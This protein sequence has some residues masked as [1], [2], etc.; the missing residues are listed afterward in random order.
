[1][2]TQAIFQKPPWK[3]G[4]GGGGLCAPVFLSWIVKDPQDPVA[5]SSSLR[6]SAPAAG[7]ET[8]ERVTAG[9]EVGVAVG[10]RGFGLSGAAAR[11]R[12][13]RQ[14]ARQLAGWMEP[15]QRP[16]VSARGCSA[17][18]GRWP[19]QR[20][21]GRRSTRGTGWL[22]PASRLRDAVTVGQLIGPA[23][24]HSSRQQVRCSATNSDDMRLR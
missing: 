12:H 17:S 24:R 5:G 20:C 14:A 15:E 1:M 2:I 10:V 21:A 22:C 7:A 4:C 8:G 6:G 23:E 19:A 3:S 13:C 16:G 9:A 18:C 11:R